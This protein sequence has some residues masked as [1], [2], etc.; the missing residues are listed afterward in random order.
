MTLLTH[1]IKSEVNQQVSK[2]RQDLDE[3]TKST[4]NHLNYENFKR[5]LMN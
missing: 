4:A 3:L 5:E 1:Q 2:V